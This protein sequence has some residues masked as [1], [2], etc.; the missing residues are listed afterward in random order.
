MRNDDNEVDQLN[1]CEV[2]A[3]TVM[4]SRSSMPP[5]A[6]TLPSAWICE[7]NGGSLGS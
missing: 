1:T 4:S 7:M 3:N 6:I 2:T 5:L